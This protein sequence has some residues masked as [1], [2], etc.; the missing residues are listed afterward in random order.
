MSKVGDERERK[1]RGKEMGEKDEERK[2]EKEMVEKDE[3]R[4][5]ERTRP[6][7]NGSLF[8][9]KHNTRFLPLSLSLSSSPSSLC[10]QDNGI[11]WKLRDR[12]LS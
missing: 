1:K 7:R 5:R 6:H 4:E 2:R 10:A 12:P 3:V 8:V 9:S 11:F